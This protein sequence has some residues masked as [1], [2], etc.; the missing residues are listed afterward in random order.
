MS[1]RVVLDAGHGMETAGK[2]AP[3]RSYYEHEFALDMARRVKLLLVQ[4]GVEVFL[5]RS[6]EHELS[7]TRRAQLSNAWKGDLFVSFHSNAAGMGDT[8]NAARGYGIYT[9]KAGDTAG[10]NLAAR[11]I[12][13]RA[14]QAGIPLWGGGLHHQGWTVLTETDAPA[15]LI[16]HLFHD[17]REDVELLKSDSF[18]DKLAEVDAKGILDYLGIPWYQPEREKTEFCCPCCGSTLKV[19][20]G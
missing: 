6:D 5:T 19:G 2:C 16:E 17:N 4:R 14:Q 18:R 7:N 1:K 13:A 8:W 15:V 10:R 9:S 3:D 20:K 11:A 12:L